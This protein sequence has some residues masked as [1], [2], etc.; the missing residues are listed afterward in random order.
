MLSKSCYG[1]AFACPW[2]NDQ[3]SHFE[4]IRALLLP[5]AGLFTFSPDTAT[6]KALSTSGP[7]P[8]GRIWTGFAATPNGTLYL[9]DGATDGA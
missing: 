3:V 7:V 1:V 6:W 5:S 9:F 4:P 2:I 8:P